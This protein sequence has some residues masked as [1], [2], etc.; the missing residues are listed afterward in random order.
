M[1][2]FLKVVGIIFAVIVALAILLPVLFK[3]KIIELAKTEINKN[4]K[5]QVDF[6]GFNL[7]LIRSFPNLQFTI[8]GLTVAGVD[9]FEGDT[10]ADISAVRITLD[11]LSA[12][13]GD[14]YEIKRIRMDKPRFLIKVLESG[15]ANYDIAIDAEEDVAEEPGDEESSFRLSLKRVEIR[16][17]F[18]I[19][20][21]AELETYVKLTGVNHLLSGDMTLE[22]T[23]LKTKT[24]AEHLTLNYEGINYLSGVKLVYLADIIADLKNN[25][26]TLSDNELLLN[27]L[28]LAF[29]GSVALLDEGYDLD[30]TYNAPKTEFRS[31]LSLVP[32]IY[33]TDFASVQTSGNITLNGFVKGTYTDDMLPA[34]ELNLLIEEG[35]F[36]YPDLPQSVSDVSIITKITNSG[37]DADNTVIDVS[38]FKMNMGMNPFEMHLLVRTPV[39]DPDLNAGFKGS[40]DLGGIGN[41]YPL[42][43]GDEMKGRF[44]MDVELEGR[45][46]SIENEKYDEFI[47][48]GNM[49][50]EGFEYKTATMN[51]VMKITSARLDFTPR[52]LKM[53]EFGMN[54]GRNDLNANGTIDNYLG[55]AFRDEMLRG[56]FAIQSN[57]FNINDL[58]PSVDESTTQPQESE[59]TEPVSVIEIPGN[60]DFELTSAF[61]KV[62]YDSIE[63]EDVTG[64]IIVKDKSLI[65]DNLNMKLL[66]GEMALK[67]SYSTA[68]IESPV[69]DFDFAMKNI[70]IQKAYQAFDLVS[71]Y[72]PI[73]SRTTGKLSSEFRLNSSLDNEM[74]LVYESIAG[75]GEL[76]SSAIV[77]EGVN[78]LDKIADVLKTDQLRKMVIDQVTIKFKFEDGKVR[79][80][81]FDLNFNKLN[82]TISGWT[83]FDQNIDYVMNL[84][85][86]RKE[87]G[88][89][90][91]EVLGNLIDQANA[92]GAGITLSELISINLLIGGTISDPT[93]RTDLA[94][95][96]KGLIDDVKQKIEDEIVKIKEDV[97]QDVKDRAQK[98]IND[99]NAQAQKLITEA[100]KQAEQIRKTAAE[101]AAKI[102]QETEKQASNVEAEGKK[103]GLIAERVAKETAK[104]MRDEAD[105]QANNVI[106]EGDQQASSLIQKANNEA[107]KIKKSAEDEV[108]KLM[109][110]N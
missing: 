36:Q 61:K 86:P 15:E 79:L 10:L 22:T 33:T 108:N 60:I 103:Q 76:R 4:V 5:A 57:Y 96:G 29:D 88:T 39:S 102:R 11:L 72:A 104:K 17:G 75:G 95:A 27:D 44:T 82:S 41:I 54:L 37:G 94:E 9:E 14:N 93:I 84:Q 3:G 92:K 7:S 40:I 21:D 99:A 20:D 34:F 81:P 62:V 43:E 97:T 2:T 55:F 19:Y 100:E 49:T 110:G 59:T 90:A 26:Y 107:D 6:T 69:V 109:E 68:D 85:L 13:K 48:R 30:M 51:D 71:V 101:T 56:R 12:I 35:M 32:A 105:K 91:N 67:G 1:K 74:N 16:D 23:T 83:S 66:D 38:K 63:M 98:I 46:S 80:E 18:I 8:R 106:N 78:T 58:M 73:A 50:V 53:A 45:L 25:I 47:A 28:A 87:L 70:D 64:K 89:A 77:I 24:T 31:L 52:F 42:E 65:L